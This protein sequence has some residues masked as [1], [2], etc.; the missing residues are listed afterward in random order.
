MNA[1][2]TKATLELNLLTTKLSKQTK[3][4]DVGHAKL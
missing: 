2:G 4:F 1:Y 3:Q